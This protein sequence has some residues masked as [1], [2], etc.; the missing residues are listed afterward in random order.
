VS[1]KKLEINGYKVFVYKTK[2]YSTIHMRFL[3]E[4]DYTRE[5]IFLSDLLEEYMV[6]TN[7]KYKTTKDIC[8][9]CTELYSTNVNLINFN[10]GN[11]LFSSM[12]INVYDPELVRD[13][14]LKS[15]LE[16]ARDILFYPNFENG[17]LDK[18]VLNVCKDS[19]ISRVGAS[20]LNYQTKASIDFEKNIYPDTYRTISILESKEEYEKL[21]NRFEDQDFIDLHDNIF[22]RSIVGLVLVG[23]IKDEY[24][25]YIEEFFKFK[26]TKELDENYQRKLKISNK[27]PFFTKK[28]DSECEESILRVLYSCPARGLKNQLIYGIISTMLGSTGMILHK[29][30]RE[31]LGIVYRSNVGHNKIQGTLTFTAYINKDNLEKAIKGIDD[32]ISLLDDKKLLESLLKQV[33]EK[34]ELYLYTFDENKRNVIEE[35]IDLSFNFDISEKKQDKIIQ[36]ITSDDILKALKNIKKEKIHF[37]E[38]VKE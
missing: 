17:K 26:Q 2:K 6:N 12:I 29:V 5:N 33:K 21:I 19:L 31:D 14:Y 20:L 32:A 35:T 24:L 10:I 34:S 9:K 30:L 3:F 18:K 38:G 8:D 13:N 23:N 4:T 15:A 7:K 25:K 37:Y 1:I 36:S 28:S 16:F 11:K 22:Q 27:T